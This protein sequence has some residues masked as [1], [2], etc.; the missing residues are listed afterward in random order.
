MIPPGAKPHS[1]P[2]PPFAPFFALAAID[3]LFGVGAW[4]LRLASPD[5][6]RPTAPDLVF[7]HAR[8]MLYGYLCAVLAGFLLTALPR[9]TRRNIPAWN[10]RLILVLWLVGRFAP[11]PPSP[12]AFAAAL[13]AIALA[14]VAAFHIVA[15]RDWRNAKTVA[16][17]GVYSGAK[18]FL[19]VAADE[20]TR[21]SATRLAIAAMMGLVMIIG[22]RVL[23]AL[24]SRYD[25]LCGE[26]PSPPRGQGIER[27][28]SLSA[29]AGLIGWLTLRGGDALAGMLFA[30]AIGQ[31]LRMAFWLG[32]RTAASPPLRAFYL[33]YA[34]IPAG[35]ALMAAHALAPGLVPESA[36]LHLWMAGGFGGMTLAIMSSMIRKRSDLAFV[37]SRAGAATALSWFA[38]ALLR[39]AA[40]IAPLPAPWLIAAAAAWVLAFALFLYDFRRPLLRRLI[41]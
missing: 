10:S 36:A 19:V 4:A 40:A 7:W 29:T 15:A 26:A 22:G 18:V 1:L 17:L 39:A 27:F 9:W 5:A 33:A 16:L 35:F 37:T 28:A 32:H 14:A 20:P 3:A 13:P 25:A 30:S 41:N 12:F 24:T 23:P 8:E 11:P 6:I 31:I 2:M 38:A 34:T 21:E